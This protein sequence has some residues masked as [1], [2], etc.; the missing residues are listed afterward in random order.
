MEVSGP[1]GSL[2]PSE[3]S[4]I[5]L[6]AKFFRALGDP[7]RLRLLDF[8]LDDARTVGDCVARV[9]LSQGRVSA[10]LACLSDCGYVSSHREGRFVYYQVTDP[11]VASLIAL[12]RLIAADNSAALAHCVRI[13]SA[14]GGGVRPVAPR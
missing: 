7:T 12:V 5:E 3:N 1:V 6:I 4:G 13:D 11:R 2:L 8:L 9:G 10:H 14:T